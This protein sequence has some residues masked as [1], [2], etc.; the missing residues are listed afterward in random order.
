[1]SVKPITVEIV[2]SNMVAIRS[3]SLTS[4]QGNGLYT[5]DVFVIEIDDVS[6]LCHPT[7]PGVNIAFSIAL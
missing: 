3:G 1:M 4:G 7:D 6:C 5:Q 2:A